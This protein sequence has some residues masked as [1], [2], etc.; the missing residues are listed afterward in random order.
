MQVSLRIGLHDFGTGRTATIQRLN[1][2]GIPV[3]AWML[4]P[5]EDGYWFNM[6]NGEKAGNDMMILKNGPQKINLKWEGIG[7]DLE[8]DMNDA[9]LAFTH[10]W[11]FGWK[12]YKRLY[13]N[14]SH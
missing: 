7:L 11:K 6:H 12:V 13:D 9:K 1:Q 5:E 10:P 8:P 2:A 3:Y 4:L 14:K